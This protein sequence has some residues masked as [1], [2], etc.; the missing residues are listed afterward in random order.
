MPTR[1]RVIVLPRAFADLDSIL[2]HVAVSS[3][4]GA[5][6]V[7]DQLWRAMQG[8][9]EFP[10]RCKVHEHRKDPALA[11]RSMPVW[12]YIVYYRVDDA[13]RGVRI[14]TVRHGSRR[15]PRRFR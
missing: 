12:P 15:Q 13:T 10:H 4:Q 9:Q 3:P 14:L 7:V 5:S 8:L 2:G 11:V 6:T 1:Y